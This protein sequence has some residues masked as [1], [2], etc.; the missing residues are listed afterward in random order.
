MLK[1]YLSRMPKR[2]EFHRIVSSC[3]VSDKLPIEVHRAFAKELRL[4]IVWTA[5][6]SQPIQVKDFLRR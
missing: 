1:M 6:A 3:S 2:N 4:S 5:L